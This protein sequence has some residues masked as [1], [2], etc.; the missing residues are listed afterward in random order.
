MTPPCTR[1]IGVPN[2]TGRG[3][4]QKCGATPATPHEVSHTFRTPPGVMHHACKP[5]ESERNPQEHTRR[6]KLGGARTQAVGDP[7]DDSKTRKRNGDHRRPPRGVPSTHSQQHWSSSARGGFG[8]QIAASPPRSPAET[9]RCAPLAV[10]S[11]VGTP[12]AHLRGDRWDPRGMSRTGRY[13]GGALRARRGAPGD[14]RSLPGNPPR[15]SQIRK[16]VACSPPRD[17]RR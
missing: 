16:W 4:A 2:L 15:G 1:A 3:I 9:S 14:V 11:P 7:A 12:C 8:P 5:G 6:N 10:G 17:L 13:R